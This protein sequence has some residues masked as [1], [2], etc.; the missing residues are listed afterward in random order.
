MVGGV[1]TCRGRCDS[2]NSGFLVGALAVRFILL[3]H[4]PG[5]A[6]PASNDVACLTPRPSNILVNL[7]PPNWRHT[8][9]LQLIFHRPNLSELRLYR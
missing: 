3:Y 6:A 1:D 7:L 2:E 4:G 5:W 9:A 8:K